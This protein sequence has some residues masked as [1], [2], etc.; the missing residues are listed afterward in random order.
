MVNMVF[1]LGSV[2][3]HRLYV[4]AEEILG[5]VDKPPTSSANKCEVKGAVLRSFVHQR[6][7]AAAEEILREV[8]KTITL[9]LCQAKV[10]GSN[11]EGGDLLN[12][13]PGA[14]PPPTSSTE[15]SEQRDATVLQESPGPS[16]C[17]RPEVPGPSETS[18]DVDSN[19]WNYSTT[20][21]TMSHI[22]EE[23]DVGHLQATELTYE[24]QPE[25]PDWFPAQ[26]GSNDDAEPQLTNNTEASER[27]DAV[28]QQES[29]GFQMSQIK[30]ED[31]D[32]G[33]D[34]QKP[35]VGCSSSPELVKIEQD[36]AEMEC[37]IEPPESPDWFPAQHGSIDSDER[38]TTRRRTQMKTQIET[39]LGL[40]PDPAEIPSETEPESPAWT[41]AQHDGSDSDEERSDKQGAQIPAKRA[42]ASQGQSGSAKKKKRTAS[43][44]EDS[45]KSETGR[46]FCHLCGKSFRYVGHLM[47]HIRVHECQVDC[48]VCAAKFQSTKELI[49]HLQCEHA[50]IHFCDVCGRIY[51]SV[52]TLGFHKRNHGG[53][54]RFECQEC[55]KRFAR[56][57]HLIVHVRVHS[58]ERPYH[59][60][61]CGKA[62]SQSQTLTIHK[63]SHSGEK[64]YHCSVCGKLFYTSGHLK[65]HMRYHSGEKPYPC[66]VCGKR[67]TQREKM[68]RHKMTHTG[69]RPYGCHV[70]GMRYRFAQNLK[71]HLQAHERE[72]AK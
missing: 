17:L 56:K 11:E 49:S 34:R 53:Q 6:L 63:R 52:R 62:F 9:A 71:T 19:E 58:G 39:A 66:D 3:Y 4:A 43:T 65:T 8:E 30:E 46:C 25:S 2:V 59:C 48:G 23:Q 32:V 70:C 24:M 60:D 7:Y 51:A 42:T 26:R 55:G 27:C 67:F 18:G 50:D 61:I 28:Q 31:Q 54:K 29:P 14:E 40:E 44:D 12:Q 13:E 57:H 47:K 22:K 72:A 36:L 16:T 33:G 68:T 20:G 45:A 21:F 64:P 37:E 38:R 5:E 41:P 69:E 1:Q 35:D 10:S 15:V